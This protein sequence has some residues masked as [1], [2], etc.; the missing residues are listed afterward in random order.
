MKNV[1]RT[2]FALWYLVGWLVHLY[3]ALFSPATYAPLGSAAAISWL[4][5]TWQATIMPRI[6]FFALLLAAFELITGSLLIARGRWVKLGLILSMAFNL[7]LVVLG[8]GWSTTSALQD[9][10]SNRL[11]N[12]AFA[13]AQLPLLRL[14]Y[15]R[16]VLQIVRHRL[17]RTPPGTPHERQVR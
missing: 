2:F 7:F 4:A 15:A 13:V 1:A 5:T 9:I 11:P 3:L 14:S 6:R 16:S 17:R 10:T 12:L 8:L